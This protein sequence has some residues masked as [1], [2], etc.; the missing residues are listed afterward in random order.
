MSY[1]PPRRQRL[2][3]LNDAVFTHRI[4]KSNELFHCAGR[5]P[6]LSPQDIS[7]FMQEHNLAWKDWPSSTSNSPTRTSELGT[8]EATKKKSPKARSPSSSKGAEESQADEDT[9]MV[10]RGMRRLVR[11]S[12]STS[13][14][15]ASIADYGFVPSSGDACRIVLLSEHSGNAGYSIPGALSSSSRLLLL[16]MASS[17]DRMRNKITSWY[18]FKIE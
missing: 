14:H 12:K 8:L 3:R 16:S 9:K 5:R 11:R 17:K 7:P 18:N 4:C 1:Q 2:H 15:E 13:S 10:S 6:T